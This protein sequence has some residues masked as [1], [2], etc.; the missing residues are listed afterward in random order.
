MERSQM[1]YLLKLRPP[2]GPVCNE[3]YPDLIL[4]IDDVVLRAGF[5]SVNSVDFHVA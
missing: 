4:P 1:V 5:G 2:L 3:G